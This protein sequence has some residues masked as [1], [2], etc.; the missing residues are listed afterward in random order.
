[1]WSRRK[2]MLFFCIWFSFPFSLFASENIW[3]EA[4]HLKGIKGR[5]FSSMDI[6]AQVKGSWGYSGPGVCPEWIQGGESGWLS[7]ACRA[8]ES[9]A[10]ASYDFEVPVSGKYRL[11]VRYGDWYKTTEEFGVQVI[12]DNKTVA[13]LV[14]GQKPIVDELDQ[15]KLLWKWVFVWDYR[16]VE[17]NKGKAQIVLLSLKP[18]EVVR[19]VDTFCL[20]TDSS[21][22]PYYR[23]KPDTSAW[24]VLEDYNKANKP[25]GES[26][27]DKKVS[28]DVPESWKLRTFRDKGFLYLWFIDAV[29][30]S[31]LIS[32][33]PARI[34]YPY[35]VDPLW[36]TEFKQIYG[37]KDDVP[38]FSHP[39]SIPTIYIND[40]PAFL[41]DNS[42]FLKWFTENERPFTMSLN[43]G[44][45][46]F[47]N[48]ETEKPQAYANFTKFKDRFFGYIS[49][50][51]LGYFDCDTAKLNQK[52]KEAKTRQ[53]VLNALTEIYTPGNTAKYKDMYGVEPQNAWEDVI[54]CLSSAC[55]SYAFPAYEWG[56]RTMGHENTSNTFLPLRLAYLRG[57]AR[58]YG[59]MFLSYRSC[60]FGDA[61]TIYCNQQSYH[62]SR[63]VYD[64]WYDAWAGAGMDWYKKDIYLYYLQ[65]ASAFHEEE[66]F[67]EFWKPG[68]GAFGEKPLQLSPKGRIVEHFLNMITKHPERSTPY[69]P[70]AF[71]IDIAAGYD[72]Q[73]YQP[74]YFDL[75]ISLNEGLL[76][77]DD[78]ARMMSEWYN[79]AY[80]PLGK[81]WGEPCTGTRQTYVPGIFG[82]VFD[83][84]ATSPTKRDIINTYPV[85]ICNG[86]IYLTREWGGT[87]IN[88]LK[89]GGTLVITEDQLSGPGTS[90]LNLP[91]ENGLGESDKFLWLLD[92][93]EYDSNTFR[94]A[95]IK[96]T[97]KVLA[98]TQGSEPL[99][100]MEQRGK[101]NLIYIAIPKGLG[102]NGEATPILSLLMIHLT[103]GLLPVKV[104]G[105]VEYFLSRLKDG[106]LVTL[107]NNEGVYKPQHGQMVTKYEEETPVI[108][109]TD[110]KIKEAVEWETE[111]KIPVTKTDKGSEIKITVPSGAIRILEIR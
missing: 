12:Q 76:L 53:E 10:K 87:L 26:L 62:G 95:K 81:R 31:K 96:T 70:V 20:T 79:I 38:I 52:I 101:G 18:Q 4:E 57:G 29:Q 44:T 30:F 46:L 60:N 41:L 42:S 92:N 37:G 85:V 109:T 86:E 33:D 63:Y 68:G 98:Q 48:I 34:K 13:D 67:D 94:Y 47:K 55:M 110:L 93:K 107:V 77:Y 40:Y 7:I 71:L 51:N 36:E 16:E 22:R 91:A 90:L 28:F 108:L 5:C 2:Y 45:P 80:Y 35:V 88:Y 1:M 89:Q 103:Q 102:I 14:Y 104:D 83:V 50:E 73:N 74:T 32:N 66:P 6:S 78:H 25:E 21:Y 3:I 27:V 54:P 84:I 58:Q 75:D 23:E 65:G 56:V 99:V 49:G 39:S 11:W 72:P 82:D 9:N 97:G 17:L 61:A 64:N 15:M 100:T 69:T 106:W 19:Q 105:N 111:E 24:Q 59:R 43:Y 8:D